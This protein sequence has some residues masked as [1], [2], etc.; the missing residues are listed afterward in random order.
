MLAHANQPPSGFGAVGEA[1][2]R[3]ARLQQRPGVA[4]F[5]W[6][7][8]PLNVITAPLVYSLAVPLVLAD[9]WIT[10]YQWIC[11]PV[12]GIARVRR[13]NYFVLDRHRL[14]YLNAIEK[15]N[16]TYCSY[17]NGLLAYIREIAA[18]TEEYWCPIKHSR[19]VRAP[20]RRYRRFAEYGDAAGYRAR[21]AVGAARRRTG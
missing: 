5:L 11:F 15:V 18:R 1:S 3:P 9:I 13:T 21:G 19:R 20:H 16:C 7:A 4:A 14:T 17:A 2:V 12:Y 6:D 8:S 10:L